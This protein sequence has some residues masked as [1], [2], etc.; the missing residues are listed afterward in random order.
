MLA[1]DKVQKFSSPSTPSGYKTNERKLLRNFSHLYCKLISHSVLLLQLSNFFKL[2]L[3]FPSLFANLQLKFY[4]P[5]SAASTQ[6]QQQYTTKCLQ[7]I[8]ICCIIELLSLIATR[9]QYHHQYTTEELFS[10]SRSNHR[11]IRE[12]Q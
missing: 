7:A 3:N 2:L 9:L 12:R 11:A 5:L 8:P 4:R 10:S 1:L 6:Q